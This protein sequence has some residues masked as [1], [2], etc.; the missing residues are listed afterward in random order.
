MPD[1]QVKICGLTRPADAEY[2]A[3]AG[4]DYLGCVLVPSS[5]RAVDAERARG[6]SSAAPGV[7]LVLV[8][9]GLG[10]TELEAAATVAG[11]SVLQ[12]H[13]DE[14]PDLVR[15]LR[16]RGPWRVWKGVR[17]RDAASAREALDRWGGIVDGILLDGWAPHQL[18]G[19]GT[20]FP[21]EE[22]ASLRPAVPEGTLLIAAGGLKPENVGRA[23]SL[24]RPDV[25]DVSSGVESTPGV[26]DPARVR[27][28]VLR[29]RT[30]TPTLDP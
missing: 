2:A 10:V 21:W 6:V 28:F 25:V 11:A 20:P 9:A 7:P 19:T 3:A 5:P 24:L 17:V 13:G 4:A 16:S 18:G 30:P 26:K 14:T 12:L 15:A 22:V 1:V 27:E 8:V 29:A 23:V